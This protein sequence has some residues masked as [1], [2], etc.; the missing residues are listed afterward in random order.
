MG[1]SHKLS[2]KKRIAALGA[3]TCT[4]LFFWLIG[5][6]SCASATGA[7][8]AATRT[9]ERILVYGDSI[10][11][12][13]V[14]V[15][16]PSPAPDRYPFNERWTGILEVELGKKYTVVEEALNGRTAGV[17]TFSAVDDSIHQY[18][19]INGRPP[20]FSILRSH[21]PLTLVIIMLGTNDTRRAANQ[22]LS[23][24]GA[25]LTELIKIAQLGARLSP[26]PKVLV[27]APPPGQK[28]QNESFNASF[29]GSYELAK[30][31]GDEFKRVA[32]A[33][34]V[35]FLDAADYIPVADGSDGI[36]LTV[37]GNK[38]LGKAV[39]VKVKEILASGK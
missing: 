37:E 4:V 18:A 38:L 2:G 16:V 7:A 32:Q 12:G 39:A 10:S 21:E 34:G 24:I 8:V 30:Q 25:S 36:H 9:E 28:A 3:I 29:E 33:E 6:N 22:S 19:N 1:L 26:R 27:I 17:D 31:L 13:Y 35:Y 5:L 14:P 11:W 23:Q 20:F 15:T